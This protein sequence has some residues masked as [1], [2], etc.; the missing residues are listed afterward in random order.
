MLALFPEITSCAESGN[1]ERLASM[2]RQYFVADLEA[3]GC[4]DVHTLVKNFGIPVRHEFLD[5]FGVLAVGDFNGEIS[6][7]I[8]IN[9]S[10]SREQQNF[11]LCHLL[12]HFIFHV[13]PLLVRG[14]WKSSGF[15]ETNCPMQRY[16]HADG[17]SGMSA[18]EFALEDLADRF[19][20]TLLMPADTV[21]NVLGSAT[22]PMRLA[23]IFGV[24]VE[25]ATR[26]LDEL[27]GRTQ[28][29]AGVVS[30]SATNDGGAKILR[31][32]DLHADRLEVP[33]NQLIRDVKQPVPP[34]SRL[35][36]AHSYSDVAQ[37]E[38]K[39][40][41]GSEDS[42]ELKGMARLRELARKLDKFGDK[43]R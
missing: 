33:S 5:S 28:R 35:V 41:K 23:Q 32:R 21:F 2:V 39:Q 7:S 1:I 15:R 9:R 18:H 30:R 8:V 34:P 19:A 12:G 26:R 43:S 38:S 42:G 20:A 25:V 4:L 40:R 10:V 22:D 13:Q 16:A 14:E 29:Q 17:L 24:T 6:S 11:T 36:A 37:S 27:N 31:S 3:S